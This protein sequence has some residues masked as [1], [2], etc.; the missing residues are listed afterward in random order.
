MAAYDG[1]RF[2]IQRNQYHFSRSIRA[3]VKDRRHESPWLNDLVCFRGRPGVWRIFRHDEKGEP[4]VE[5]HG[6]LKSAIAT[7]LLLKS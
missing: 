1:K 4:F 2:L 3:T 7:Y 5:H 6:T